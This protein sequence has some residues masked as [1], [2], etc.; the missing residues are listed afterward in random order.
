MSSPTPESTLKDYL[1]DGVAKEIFFAEEAEFLAHE[2]GK[3]AD[4]LNARGFGH[5]LALPTIGCRT[6]LK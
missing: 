2:I 4:E 3:R 6:D 5:L 1:L